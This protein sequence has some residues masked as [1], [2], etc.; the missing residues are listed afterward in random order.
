MSRMGE[1]D[2]ICVDAERHARVSLAGGEKPEDV[3]E[4]IFFHIFNHIGQDPDLRGWAVNQSEKV[5]QVAIQ[6]LEDGSQQN[7]DAPIL[8][9]TL[10][11]VLSVCENAGVAEGDDAQA[12][13]DAYTRLAS[14]GARYEGVREEDTVSAKGTAPTC[15]H[16]G[17]RVK[18]SPFALPGEDRC[19]DRGCR[20]CCAAHH[21]HPRA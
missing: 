10:K 17:I 9:G 3:S 7:G 11:K 14:M 15:R 16:C 8:F 4:A 5:L 18:A 2:A 13:K 21:N 6:A 12:I 1:L 19:V 20:K